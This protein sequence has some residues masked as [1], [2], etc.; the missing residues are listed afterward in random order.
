MR[1]Y[2]YIIAHDSGAAP[3]FEEP[4]P[5]LAICK[6]KIRLLAE[7]GDVVM[8]FTGKRLSPEP[9]GVCWAGV[10]HNKHTF[11]E[12]WHDPKFAS[13]KPNASITPDNI[14]K[15]SG[16]SLIQVPNSSHG[17]D[18]AA[19]DIG[20]Q[21][22]LALEPAWYFGIAAPILPAS[23][24]LRL[25]VGRRNHRTVQLSNHKWQKLESWLNRQAK[26]MEII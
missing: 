25:T 17:N 2:A 18:D 19:R 7:L 15:P 11:A 5:T 4:M 8:A 6:P 20:G 9:H 24:G 3:N 12:Y 13:K 14:Y 22:V 16:D 10:V 21:Y 26:S 1:A 23:F